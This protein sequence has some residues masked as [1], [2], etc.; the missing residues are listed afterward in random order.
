MR[1][2]D[3]SAQAGMK[4]IYEATRT[5]GGRDGRKIIEAIRSAA[6]VLDVVEA[7][8]EAALQQIRSS[9]RRAAKRAEAGPCVG[10]AADR[11]KVEVGDEKAFHG[12]GEEGRRAAA[13]SRSA[14]SGALG[15]HS[16]RCRFTPQHTV[17]VSTTSSVGSLRFF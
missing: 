2:A 1:V 13:D 15:S 11:L 14:A 10:R 16:L 7:A 3:E 12:S 8:A 9:D 17:L 5:Q 4:A 6:D